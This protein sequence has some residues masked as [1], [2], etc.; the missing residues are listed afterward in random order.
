MVCIQRKEKY[1]RAMSSTTTIDR[2]STTSYRKSI[3]LPDYCSRPLPM[4]PSPAAPPPALTKT[5]TPPAEQTIHACL[6]RD[7]RRESAARDRRSHMYRQ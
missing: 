2:L 7:Q 3:P 4:F 5:P 6:I 1:V